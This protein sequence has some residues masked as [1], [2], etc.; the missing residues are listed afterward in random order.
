MILEKC[1]GCKKRLFCAM[2][3]TKNQGKVAH[4]INEKHLIKVLLQ[5][6]SN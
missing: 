1:V 5:L 6:S 3:T 4:V 2:E